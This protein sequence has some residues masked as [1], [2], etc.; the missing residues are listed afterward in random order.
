[1]ARESRLGMLLAESF[2]R[3]WGGQ[4]VTMGGLRDVGLVLNSAVAGRFVREQNDDPALSLAELERHSGRSGLSDATGGRVVY[5]N[6]DV[7][8]DFENP[9]LI[10]PEP[11]RPLDARLPLFVVNGEH[12]LVSAA[13][14]ANANF[15]PV[16]SNVAIDQNHNTR[17]WVTDGGA[18][19]NRGTETA[20]MT[21]RYA[22]GHGA[23]ACAM[24]PA[25]HI[26]EIEA[27]AFSD[28]YRQDRG[29]GSM[30]GGG[31][32]FASQLDAELLADLKE[33]YGAPVYFHFLPMPS[34]LRRSGSF[35]THWM[36]QQRITVC[37]DV[38]C[39][40]TLE[41]TGEQVVEALRVLDQPA[42]PAPSSK[43]EEL[44]KRIAEE[45]EQA[46]AVNW[47]RLASCLAAPRGACS[48]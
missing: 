40:S 20:L 30:L 28:G 38:D 7:P 15:P 47:Q 31:A 33:R 44:R 14:A 46:H 11:P 25:L 27:S 5:T 9:T 13:A 39:R 26:V 4:L 2:E 41:V 19:D 12:V 36:L 22:L 10:D 24:R 37:K 16:F 45:E 48:R 18:I 8:D 34:L 17:L 35:G 32:A 6:L 23:D 3:H 42:P 1:M 43:V 29:L 21:I